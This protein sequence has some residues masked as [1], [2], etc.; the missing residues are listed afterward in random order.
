MSATGS[1]GLNSRDGKALAPHMQ[2]RSAL[3]RLMCMIH[4]I[5]PMSVLP[6][7]YAHP[8]RTS[9]PCP[10]HMEWTRAQ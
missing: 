5:H 9:S 3:T 10:L 2:T 6:F 7:F 8:S 4:G 1:L